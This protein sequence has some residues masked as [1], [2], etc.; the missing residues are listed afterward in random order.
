MNYSKTLSAS[1]ASLFFLIGS[2]STATHAL[3][4]IEELGKSLYFDENLSEPSG[5]SCASCHDPD[6]AFVD[7]AGE[8]GQ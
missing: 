3:T 1:Y 8:I 5:Q 6:F 2:L 4:P 7:P